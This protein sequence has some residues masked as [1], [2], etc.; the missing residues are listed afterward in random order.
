MRPIIVF[1]AIDYTLFLKSNK[2]EEVLLAVLGN[3]NGVAAEE[4]IRQVVDRIDETAQSDF[5][6]KR[7]VQQL[8][9]LAQLRNSQTQTDAIMDSLANYVSDEKDILYMRGERKARDQKEYK[10]VSIMLEEKNLTIEQIAK[11]ADVSTEFI[12]DIQR[13]LS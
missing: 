1:S 2:P 5:S 12:L 4:V 7:Y 13:Q 6:L 3:F 9:T 8:R 11:F 10:I